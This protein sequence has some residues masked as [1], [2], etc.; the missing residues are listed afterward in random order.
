MTKGNGYGYSKLQTDVG[1][2]N[3]WRRQEQ[4]RGKEEGV[5]Q[6]VNTHNKDEDRQF[7]RR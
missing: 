3:K 6:L 4:L 1:K 5:C 2:K 7:E